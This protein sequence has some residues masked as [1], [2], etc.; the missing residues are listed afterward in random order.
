[1]KMRLPVTHE[2]RLRNT[3]KPD[4][5]KY[6]LLLGFHMVE[7]KRFIMW[8]TGDIIMRLKED[9]LSCVSTQF[10]LFST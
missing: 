9:A 8:L 7:G 5:G 10:Q 4:R 6:F 1:M 3:Q 2:M